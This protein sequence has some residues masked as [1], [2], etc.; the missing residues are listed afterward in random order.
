MSAA[1]L[2]SD[3]NIVNYSLIRFNID[4][5]FSKKSS[6]IPSQQR[7]TYVTPS[8]R[9]E[10][11]RKI[12][13]LRYRCGVHRL[14][15]RLPHCLGRFTACGFPSRALMPSGDIYALRVTQC[16]LLR[17]LRPASGRQ[18]PCRVENFLSVGCVQPIV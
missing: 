16:G 11:N 14:A 5:N 4:R 1:Q 15:S 13:V 6:Q 3:T 8:S 12:A 18:T 10:R 17:R 9:A 2:G 7:S